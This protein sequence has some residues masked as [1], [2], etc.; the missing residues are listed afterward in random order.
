MAEL[1]KE[2]RRHRADEKRIGK[3]KHCAERPRKRAERISARTVGPGLEKK[4]KGMELIGR[5][6]HRQRIDMIRNG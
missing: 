1:G 2:M 4:R 6:K 3:E 5:A